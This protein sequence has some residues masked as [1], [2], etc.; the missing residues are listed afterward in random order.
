M[1]RAIRDLTNCSQKTLCCMLL[2]VAFVFALILPPATADSPS[3]PKRVAFEAVDR[4][5]D[6][7]AT[8]GDV[9]YY[10]AE[11]GMQEYESSKYLKADAWSRS[12]SKSSSAGRVYRPMFGRHG[13]RVSR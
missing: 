12:V 11:P 2:T 9:L 3:D 7:I 10:F 6:A 8:V 5:A 4:N 13:V 1:Y